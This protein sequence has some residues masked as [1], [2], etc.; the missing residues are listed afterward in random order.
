[1][2]KSPHP[3]EEMEETPEQARLNLY[4]SSYQQA[5][6]RQLML[7]QMRREEEALNLYRPLP[8]Q[9]M[10]HSCPLKE[11]II[12]KGNQTGG[13]LCGAVELARAVTG[14]DPHNKYPKTDG[15]AAVI[16]YGEQHVGRVFYPILFQPG[17]FRVIRDEVTGRKRVWQ[18]WVPADAA[19]E[20]EAENAGP[21]IPP[22]FIKS[23]AWEK[24]AERIFSRIDF[25]TGWTLYALN[26]AGD[27]SQA[28]GFKLNFCWIDEDLANSGWYQEMFGRLS[29]KKGRLRWTALPHAKNDDIINIV[30]RGDK[31]AGLADDDPE[32]T[33]RVV[34]ATIFDNPYFPPESLRDNIKAWKAEGEDVYRKRALG[35]FTFDSV[36][37]YPT[38]SRY[39][40]SATG[41]V[42]GA[43]PLQKLLAERG[44][45]PP[46]GWTRYMA[47]DPGFQVCAALFAAVPPPAEFGEHVIIYDELY[48]PN[49]TP[50]I[51]A[52]GAQQKIRDWPFEAFIIDAHGS[53][54]TSLTSGINPM[55]A[56]TEALRERNLSSVQSG[57]SFL[58]GSDDVRGRETRVRE[59]LSIPHGHTLPKLLVVLER[60][61]KLAWE[62]ER[63]KKKTHNVGGKRIPL[64][65]GERKV[66]T[67]AVEACEYLAAHGCAYRKPPSRVVSAKTPFDN[68]TERKRKQQV[69]DK[70]IA[71]LLGRNFISLGPRGVNSGSH[72][73]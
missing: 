62:I 53:K 22:R 37:M 67:H 16:G 73:Y 44:G 57:N 66:H 63:F 12:Q 72:S 42:E 49:A 11:C 5:E 24:K 68:Y 52:E 69:K 21:L 6:F 56:Y 47:V 4:G 33:T 34:R 70:A 51:F 65:D 59:W 1:M 60:C 31:E 26:S 29:M 46:E 17:Q 23:V 13:S 61:P 27:P 58:M 54:L 32:K 3:I 20:D 30:E 28:Q 39:V 40:H 8:F 15:C 64:D 9:E 19:R 25:T 14:K 41:T 18:P 38:F 71:K 36:K 55:T 50:S 43:Q 45:E 7:E 48:I 35:E 2:A 10:F